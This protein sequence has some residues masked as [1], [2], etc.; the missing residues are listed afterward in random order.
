MIK[1]K[2]KATWAVL[3]LLIMLIFSSCASIEKAESLHREG[4]K[5]KALEMAISLLEDDNVKVRLRAVKLVGKIGGPEAGDALHQRLAVP[6][7]RVQLEV[8]RTIGKNQYEPALEDLAD[9]VPDADE[10]MVRALADAFRAFGKTG[11]DLVVSRYDSPSLSSDRAAYKQV[12]I[13]IGPEI[14]DSVIKLLKGRSYFDNRDTF[15]ILKRIKNPRIATLMLPYLADEEVAEQVIE[16][17]KRLGTNAVEATINA[18]RKKKKS[19]ELLVTVSLIR[20]LGLLKAKP[21]IE[22]LLSFSQHDSDRV[23]DA[24][25][26]SLFQIRGF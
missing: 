17:L 22:M 2:H 7:G 18:L 24:V 14:A 11:T 20:I 26:Q 15:D 5:Q 4:E 10:E 8:V 13:R 19:G 1:V 6:D 23:R 25:E 21:G 16:A 9:L 3:S 12:L